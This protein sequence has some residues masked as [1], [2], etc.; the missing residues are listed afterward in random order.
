MKRQMEGRGFSPAAG[1][2]CDLGALA[3]EA[4]RLQGLNPHLQED[5]PVV[6]HQLA[7]AVGEDRRT[8]D[9]VCPLLLAAPGRGPS[10]SAAL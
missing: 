5:R 9:Q 1:S 2:R 3:P 6:A 7:A 8:F 4:R 10:D